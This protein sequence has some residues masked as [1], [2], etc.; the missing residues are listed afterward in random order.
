MLNKQSNQP[1]LLWEG[2]RPQ[3]S[4]SPR[5]SPNCHHLHRSNDLVCRRN[6]LTN[7][8]LKKGKGKGLKKK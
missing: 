8:K 6:K 3:L 1:P 5:S 2:P 4:S 7:E